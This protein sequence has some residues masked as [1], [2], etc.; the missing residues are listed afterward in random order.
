MRIPGAKALNLEQAYKAMAWLGETT[1][2]AKTIGRSRTEAIEEA[3]YR[4]RQPLLGEL[5]VAFFDTTSLY[6]EGQGGAT[7][8]QRGY[9]KDFRPQLVIGAKVWV[10]PHLTRIVFAL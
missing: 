7:L 9:S 1:T 6:F 3:L 5:S 4:H 8:G 2:S 10:A